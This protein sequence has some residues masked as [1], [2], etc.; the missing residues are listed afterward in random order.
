MILKDSL[1]DLVN[2]Q[3]P[4]WEKANFY[5]REAGLL[6]RQLFS[7]LLSDVLETKQMVSLTGLRRTGKSTLLKQVIAH[8][9][10]KQLARKILYFSFDEPAVQKTPDALSFIIDFFLKEKI[11]K[12]VHGLQEKIY[13]FF[14]EIQLVPYWQDILKRYYDLNQN[15]KFIVSGS[16]S[17]YLHKGSKESLAGRIFERQLAPLS[18]N[19][20]QKFKPE[21]SFDD[22]LDFGGF[23]EM[24]EFSETE[25]I[26]EYLKNWVI[27][28]VLEIDLPKITKI[29]QTFEFERIFWSLLPGTG[30]ILSMPNLQTDLGLKKTTAYNFLK[31]LEKS[32]LINIVYN[33]AGSYR[34]LSRVLRKIYPASSNFLSLSYEPVNRGFFVET[35]IATILLSHFS[36]LNFF[37]FRGKEIDFLIPEKKIAFEVKY[38]N[39]LRPHDY[40]FLSQYCQ[41]KKYQGVLLTKNFTGKLING[42]I[43]AFP[44]SQLENNLVV[45]NFGKRQ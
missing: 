31:L 9:L 28:K 30:Q 5:L 33:R 26:K 16:S 45:G 27:A 4:W 35:Y 11:K 39:S 23:P 34:S 38:Q 14:D 42:L 43:T 12:P 8:L 22:Y 13:L 21:G 25:R 18:F 37:H 1:I 6:K 20:Y 15:L 3:N 29:R 19:E 24:L 40:E 32:L 17:L 41:E 10:K 36:R 2:I 44:V 7:K